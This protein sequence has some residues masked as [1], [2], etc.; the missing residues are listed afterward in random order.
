MVRV[1]S[2]V[3]EPRFDKSHGTA[4]KF[5]KNRKEYKKSYRS[6]L[7]PLCDGE[8]VTATLIWE[9]VKGGS[10]MGD[11][12]TFTCM[13]ITCGKGSWKCRF[14]ITKS[15]ARAENLIST[16]LS[17]DGTQA[18]N[19]CLKKSWAS[20]WPQPPVSVWTLKGERIR[21]AFVKLPWFICKTCYRAVFK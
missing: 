3:R 17:S 6:Q 7:L 14:W 21:A 15:E 2:L 19:H 18:E 20:M 10:D 9:D 1:P 16:K 11:P 12:Q 4:N 8:I 13:W 5:L